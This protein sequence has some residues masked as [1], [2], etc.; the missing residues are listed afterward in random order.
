MEIYDE[1]RIFRLFDDLKSGN[2][3]SFE[4]FYALTKQQVFY[5]ILSIVKDHSWAEEVLQ[6]TY[7][8]F[9]EHLDD[10]SSDKNPLGYLFVV[11][12]NKSFKFLQKMKK[13]LDY[14]PL[15]NT[16]A[17]SETHEVTDDY[18][19]KKMRELLSDKEYRI[20]ILHVLDELSHKEIARRLHRP[21][22]S[23][24]WSY[25]NAIKKLQKGL[26]EYYGRQAN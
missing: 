11:S 13:D 14:E 16:M 4:D 1:S 20:V 7:V 19:F 2:M 25:S 12:K 22:G 9:L 18:I 26:G 21:L 8:A 15:E 6:E 24:T 3:S 23:V 5:N 10:I 17:L